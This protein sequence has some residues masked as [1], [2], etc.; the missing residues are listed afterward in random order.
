MAC[1]LVLVTCSAPSH[2]IN[3]YWNIVNWSFWNKVQWNF[4]QNRIIF[5]KVHFKMLSAKWRLFLLGLNVFNPYWALCSRGYIW[6]YIDIHYRGTTVVT[7]LLLLNS[8]DM[9]LFLRC[10]LWFKMT[11]Y[12]VGFSHYV[13]AV[14]SYFIDY[15]FGIIIMQV[16][17]YYLLLCL[18]NIF[19]CTDTRHIWMQ[20]ISMKQWVFHIY[21]LHLGSVWKYNSAFQ[22]INS[23]FHSQVN[24]PQR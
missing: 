5:K 6:W 17:K 10:L 11:I 21:M 12:I 20:H 3:Q 16:T 15:I 2:H 22:E 19:L 14:S 13:N 24:L 4:N 18:I 7:S 9:R 23:A 8:R 1:R